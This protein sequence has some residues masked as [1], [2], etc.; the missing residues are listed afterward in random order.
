MS[1]EIFARAKRGR[2]VEDEVEEVH[3]QKTE[4]S[5]LGKKRRFFQ[6]YGSYH[7]VI[8]QQQNILFAL[9]SQFILVTKS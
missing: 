6:T 9:C 3:R 2:V 4:K 5:E 1:D 7:G 8:L